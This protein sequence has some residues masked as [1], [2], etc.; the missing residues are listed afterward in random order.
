MRSGSDGD[1]GSG[2]L[3][4]DLLRSAASTSR[5]RSSKS[6]AMPRLSQPG[7]R[8]L[9]ARRGARGT[10]RRRVVGAVLV[11]VELE[12][13]EV[14]DVDRGVVDLVAAVNSS[15]RSSSR[16]SERSS[17]SAP[18]GPRSGSTSASSARRPVTAC[19]SSEVSSASVVCS[20]DASTSSASASMRSARPASSA[21]SPAGDSI[22]T[23]RSLATPTAAA[24]AS[25]AADRRAL[26]T[27]SRDRRGCGRLR[28]ARSSSSSWPS[29]RACSA[30]L[31]ASIGCGRPRSALRS[32]IRSASV[33]RLVDDAARPRGPPWRA[34]PRT[35]SRCGRRDRPRAR[36]ASATA[37]LGRLRLAAGGELPS[38]SFSSVSTWSA[39]CFEV[40]ADLVGV[41]AASDGRELTTAD[42]LGAGQQRQIE[43]TGG[44]R[45]NLPGESGR[46]HRASCERVGGADA[47]T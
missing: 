36:P 39:T 7:A 4:G 37:R 13:R 1:V 21:S 2:H 15:S 12:R 25:P 26:A 22:A 34:A 23:S 20:I 30:R 19:A 14:G 31:C 5:S 11:E 24:T 46:Y 29:W 27:S 28:L 10:I 33:L 16:R 6:V 42:L 18:R 40:V 32:S 38:R 8:S 44:H 43:V 3:G 17:R 41:V 35:A 9:A 47:T 45:T